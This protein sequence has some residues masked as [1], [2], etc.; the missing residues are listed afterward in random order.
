MN[1]KVITNVEAANDPDLSKAA[2]WFIRNIIGL[3]NQEVLKLSEEV[4]IADEDTDNKDYKKVE[5][6]KRK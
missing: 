1:L 2:N 4:G 3:N 5:N 6:K